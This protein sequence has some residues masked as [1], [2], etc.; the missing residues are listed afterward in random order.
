MTNSA[1][2]VGLAYLTGI[3]HVGL[4]ESVA[5]QGTTK[6]RKGKSHKEQR[7]SLRVDVRALPFLYISV[8]RPLISEF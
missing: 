3:S 2:L 1:M 8:F 4:I 6:S 7:E 5:S